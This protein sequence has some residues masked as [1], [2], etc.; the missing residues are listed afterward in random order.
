M[1]ANTDNRPIRFES[2]HGG[3]L[4]VSVLLAVGFLEYNYQTP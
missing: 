3:R 2:P 4:F 1:A